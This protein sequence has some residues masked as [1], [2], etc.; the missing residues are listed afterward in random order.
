LETL[1]RLPGSER[2]SLEGGFDAW[3]KARMAFDA[4]GKAASVKQP[5]APTVSKRVTPPK[6]R[7][8]PTSSRA[9]PAAKIPRAAMDIRTSAE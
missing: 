2:M 4:A 3:A 1:Q 7:P 8:T 5:A 6:N 9:R